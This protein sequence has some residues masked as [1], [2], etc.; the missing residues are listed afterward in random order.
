MMRKLRGRG[1]QELAGKQ[2]PGRRFGDFTVFVSEKEE[3]P[4]KR[5]GMTFQRAMRI[6]WR[7]IRKGENPLINIGCVA[8]HDPGVTMSGF[9]RE[10]LGLVLARNQ[11]RGFFKA[12]VEALD[13]A[14]PESMRSVFEEMVGWMGAVRLYASSE[15]SAGMI[16][17]IVDGY[18]DSL[19]KKYGL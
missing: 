12:A 13:A 14:E 2:V 16:Q 4:P 5:Q 18:A 10:K 7:A 9:T 17:E 11:A 8:F 15:R 1:R 3:A 6:S 19:R